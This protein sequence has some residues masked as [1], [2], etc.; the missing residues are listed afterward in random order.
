[1]LKLAPL[2]RT[3]GYKRQPPSGGCVLKLLSDEALAVLTA[4]PPSGGCVLKQV[5]AEVQAVAEAQP[6]SGGCVL[7]LM[8]FKK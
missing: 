3:Y 8:T 1:M 4:Q 7:K 2:A 6:P 5:V